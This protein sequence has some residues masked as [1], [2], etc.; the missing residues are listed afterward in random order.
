MKKDKNIKVSIN[1]SKKR[2]RSAINKEV[3]GDES[4]KHDA[5]LKKTTRE[6]KKAQ[7][8][9]TDGLYI[10]NKHNKKIEDIREKRIG[11]TKL[12]VQQEI[13]EEQIERRNKKMFFRRFILFFVLLIIVILVYL[14]FEYG[15]IFGISM[16]SS[17]TNNKRIDIVSTDSDIYKMYNDELLI[18]SN[19]QIVTYDKY[20]NNTWSYKL[21]Q[22]FTPNIY[23]CGK[24]MIVSNNING[25]VYLFEEKKEILN[26]KIEGTIQHVYMDELGNFAV[27][28]ST[29]IYKKVIGVYN[30]SGKN[31]FNTY[32]E[33]NAIIDIKILEKG[34]K[35]LIAKANSSS[36][37]IGCSLSIIDGSSTAKEQETQISKF[38]NN[39]I[40]NLTIHGQD[41]IILLD[42]KLVK[43]NLTTK[44]VTEI[45]SFTTAQLMYVSTYKDYY[46]S[47]DKKLD[48]ENIY[49]ITT[50]DYANHIISQIDEN[51][52]PKIMMNSGLITYFI[53]QNNIKVM[54]KWGI[55][56]KNQP[57]DGTPKEVIVFNKEKSLAL[58]YTNKIYIMNI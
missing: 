37:K 52:S 55:E 53:Y 57:L 5:I 32:L 18:Y 46:I 12:E 11:K 25:T 13:V 35:L 31:L 54:N 22:A 56:I 2:I 8:S 9:L 50:S 21:D 4:P 17:N 1:N 20:G 58:V 44:E 28:Y 34:N 3:I 38:D 43:L 23:S 15:P 41:I 33:N 16:A 29:S 42:N 24:Y 45:K 36:F 10:V 49:S 6:D 47:V 26:K 14:F 19:Q 48:N 7:N 51:E 27:E 40:Y 39:L 30:K